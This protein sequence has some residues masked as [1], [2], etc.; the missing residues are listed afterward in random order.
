MKKAAKARF[1]ASRRMQRQNQWALW[2]L[3]LFSTGLIVLTLLPSSGIVLHATPQLQT[4]L[5]TVLAL[6]VLVLSLL[7]SAHN[8]S[9]KAEKMHRCAL[10]MN[11]LCHKILPFCQENTD[12]ELYRKT[13]EEYG[14]I[15]NAYENH[16]NIDF[17]LVRLDMPQEYPL[18]NFEKFLI[19]IR[20]WLS[21][22]LYVALLLVL[23]VTFYILLK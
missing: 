18:T 3:S 14:G 2:T 5:Q 17:D 12:Q 16:Q 21:F 23:P 15:L 13:F 7:L 11:A 6:L 10:E 8:F 19:H 4:F 1:N 22:W 9:E 20:Y